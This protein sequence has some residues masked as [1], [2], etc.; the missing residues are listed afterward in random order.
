MRPEEFISVFHEHLMECKEWVADEDPQFVLGYITG[1]F[2]ALEAELN[3]QNK[4]KEVKS[5]E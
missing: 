1:Q 3:H 2:E 4:L 5:N